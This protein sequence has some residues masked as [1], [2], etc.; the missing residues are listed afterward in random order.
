MGGTETKD[1]G[2]KEKSAVNSGGGH[3]GRL[4]RGG[5]IYLVLGAEE[6]FSGR[7]EGT[8]FP[9]EQQVERPDYQPIHIFSEGETQQHLTGPPV[10]R[11]TP[12]DSVVETQ[13]PW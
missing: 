12:G 10:K 2:S 11:I 1:C 8:D 9:E 7:R 3:Q 13:M 5:V 6:D 4:N